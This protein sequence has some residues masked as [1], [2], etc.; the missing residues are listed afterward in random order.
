MFHWTRS[1]DEFQAVLRPPEMA[2][3]MQICDKSIREYKAA[4]KPGS[5]RDSL[6]TLIS[7]RDEDGSSLSHQELVGV[8]SILLVAG[9][10]FPSRSKPHLTADI[11]V[12]TTAIALT[13]I[14]YE[15]A[16]HPEYFSKLYHEIEKYKTVDELQSSEL[17]KLPLLNA[18]IRESLRLSPPVP[19]PVSTRQCPPEG[20]NL[21]G[22]FIP[23]GVYQVLRNFL[24]LD[25]SKSRCVDIMSRSTFV[26]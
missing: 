9:N 11:G 26:S 25:E 20:T 12:D 23:G 24:Y 7:S 5:R 14:S 22:Y 2:D 16:K 6:S 10:F 3:N 17:E 8:A 15:L 4:V 18:V 19:G 21:G 1:R 13:F